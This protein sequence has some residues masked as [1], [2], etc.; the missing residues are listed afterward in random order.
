MEGG[1]PVEQTIWEGSEELSGWV[2]QPYLGAEGALAEAGLQVGD[3]IRVYF[4]TT[5][6]EW[7]FQIYGGHW[8]GLYFAEVGGNEISH[9]NYNPGDGYF[10]FTVTDDL[11][12][13][14]TLA[15]QGWGG[16][17]VVQGDGVVVTKMAIQ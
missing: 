6:D 9:S 3:K 8:E 5:N 16:C 1:G 12:G 10:E 7:I 14:L 17:M 2:N 11:I 13:P 15:G 4:T